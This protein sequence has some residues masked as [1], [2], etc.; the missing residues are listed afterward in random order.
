MKGKRLLILGAAFA[1]GLSACAN[2]TTTLRKTPL[3]AA[4]NTT[5]FS[6]INNVS[7][8][9]ADKSYIITSGTS[10]SV[11]AISTASNTNNRKTT[12]ITVSDGKITRGSSVMSFTLGGETGAWTFATENY[13]GTAGYLKNADS[14]TNNYLLVGSPARAFTITFNSDAAV[15]TATSGSARNL[16]R[17]NSSSDLFACYASG[18]NNV[19][20]WKEIE[21]GADLPIVTGVSVSGDMSVK[22]YSTFDNLWNNNGL[23]ASVTMSDGSSYSSDIEW[24]FT[25]A[26]PLAYVA[27]NKDDVTGGTILAVAT[28]GGES[29]SKEITG[30]SVNCGTIDEALSAIPSAGDT[31]SDAIVK[32]IVSSIDSLDTG[33]YGNATYFI[34]EDGDNSSAKLE[35]YRGKGL[36]G[37]KFTNTN[38]LLVGDTVVVRGSLKNFNGTKEFDANS[39]I[40]KLDR[41]ASADPI[42][43]ITESHA[44]VFVG[45]TDVTLHAV[46][47]NV[48]EG[49]SVK[50][51]SQDT[52]IATVNA[53]TGAVH[54]V[55]LG[56]TSIVANIV[57]GSDNVLAANSLSVNVVEDLLNN[58]D[59]FVVKATHDADTY[60][61]TGV[62]NNLGTTN[63][64]KS[65]AVVLTAAAGEVFGQYKLAYDGNYLSYSGSSNALNSTT[66]G[67]GNATL[68]N[69]YTDG[70]DAFIES[71]NVPG[72]KLQFN[73][74]NG[75]PRFACYAS[76][77]T[78]VVVEKETTPV[79]SDHTVTFNS[80]GGTSVASQTVSYSGLAVKP[81]DPTKDNFDFGGWYSDEGLQN[82]FDFETPITTD[83][84]LYAKWIEKAALTTE[85]TI[86]V[87]ITNESDLIDGTYLISYK[88]TGIVFDGSLDSSSID[89]AENSVE[90]DFAN[91]RFV[92]DNTKVEEAYFTIE[93][94]GEDANT[95]Y[96]K[97]SSDLY[98]GKDAYSNGLDKSSTTKY[99]NTISFDEDGN[100]II[101]GEGGCTLRYNKASDQLR[102]RY[103]KT[104]Q[105]AVQLYRFYSLDE[106]LKDFDS[107]AN[108]Y[109]TETQEEG[110][111]SVSGVNIRFGATI[112]E[113]KWNAISSIWEIADYGVKLVKKT[114]GSYESLTPVQDRIAAGKSVSTFS[115]GSGDAPT[116][117]EGMC[118]FEVKINVTNYGTNFY[119]AP[120]ILVGGKLY[121]LDEVHASVNELAQNYSGSELSDDALDILAH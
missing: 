88:D 107:F 57:D 111:V 18:Q 50:W 14:G 112:S 16:M 69:V 91:S 48:P 62:S 83:I 55:S 119:A 115:K 85:K 65:D 98:I 89:T 82:K 84:T 70:E 97:S 61:L 25:P 41:P 118:T 51:S 103:Y 42:V 15:I 23:N 11:K 6:L 26:S 64:N 80:N 24:S 121:F 59:E 33:S 87:K 76:N 34:T 38:D 60:Y 45:G 86:F 102:F 1:L 17:Y 4:S 67:E 94:D 8:L 120:Y 96:I 32:G 22:T 117:V 95:K 20:L 7:D 74:N 99:K 78:A 21:S 54:A 31:V 29:G 72:R 53:T 56:S 77:Q 2:G 44:N 114:T 52:T 71:V 104:G 93:S 66:N 79:V 90:A 81:A 30:I 12:S 19:Y 101:E 13:A 5:Q 36:N 110:A 27:S 49:G 105:Q 75:N 113:E 92:L 3:Q 39:Q 46:A 116:A 100:A 63:T 28:A 40:L 37:N 47:E 106:C 43:T 108:L 35:V 58:G 109:A 10:G 68:W 73:F 9:E